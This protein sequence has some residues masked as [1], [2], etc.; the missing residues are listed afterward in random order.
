MSKRMPSPENGSWPLVQDLF[1]RGEPAF[2]DELR[3]FHDPDVLGPFATQW[4]NDRR[5]ASRRLLLDY[6]DRPMN[7]PRHEPLIKRLFKLA[8]AAGDDEVVGRF[9]VLFDRS[10]RRSRRSRWVYDRKA[11][12]SVTFEVAGP[13]SFGE[14]PKNEPQHF[15]DMNEW[16]KER[17]EKSRLFSGRT[18]NYL[19]RRAWR[20]FRKLGRAVPE[21]YFA[22]IRAVLTRYVDA[23]VADG[24]ALL[25]NWGLVHVLFHFSPALVSNPSGWVMAK[26]A[27]LSDIKPAPMFVELWKADPEPLLELLDTAPSRAV[28][29]WAV[30]MLRE[31]HPDALPGLPVEKLVAWL[32]HRSSEMVSLAADLL[33]KG[34]KLS[35]VGADQLLEIVRNAPPESLELICELASEAL[36]P[37]Q[38]T[39]RQAVELAKQPTEAVARLGFGLLQK[40]KPATPEDCRAL[41][42]L[43][44]AGS[45]KLRADMVR[46]A[47]KQ[48][49]ASPHFTSEWVVELLDSRFEE[50]RAV[51]WAWLEKEPRALDD[52]HVWQQLLESPYDTIRIR[53]V[54]HLQK[55]AAGEAPAATADLDPGLIRFLWASVLLNVARGS[56][57]KPAV[58]DMVVRRV[59]NRS[60]EAEVLLPILAVALRSLRGPEFRAGL[61][62]VLGFVHD[63]P[64]AEELVRRLFP[65]LK[66]VPIVTAAAS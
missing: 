27:K 30:Q 13:S 5:P 43:A 49:A 56:R 23:D 17:F 19:R 4:Y 9:M 47:C 58:I 64:E 44:D 18:R 66:R 62:G 3:R 11:K 39:V 60:E 28:R 59:R 53:I 45:S 48:L 12:K 42:E 31:E 20:Y 34:K 57:A 15:D 24:L 25:D 55:T 38:V 21:R 40:M 35:G 2:V 7:A 1:D 6:L 54:E 33:R 26:D 22:A 37:S 65:E 10:V 32:G 29:M 16:Q 63:R 50:V 41:L 52:P 8:E 51:G 61:L 14:M 36:K 46:W